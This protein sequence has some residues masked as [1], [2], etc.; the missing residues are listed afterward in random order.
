MSQRVV[1]QL[2]LPLAAQ[3]NRGI[4][5]IA[6]LKQLLHAGKQFV[7]RS[8]R[9]YG[10]TNSSHL[11]VPGRAGAAF[12]KISFDARAQFVDFVIAQLSDRNDDCDPH[13]KEHHRGEATAAIDEQHRQQSKCRAD[14]I[15]HQDHAAL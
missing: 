8:G 13:D 2:R 4:N 1:V 12:T 6:W 15:E 5:K 10:A 14:S 3:L 7:Q 11:Y 9:G